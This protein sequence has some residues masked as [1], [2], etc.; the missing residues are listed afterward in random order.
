MST[1]HFITD[2]SRHIWETKYRYRDGNTPV[3]QSIE[4]TWK[5]IATGLAEAEPADKGLWQAR[6]YSVL[7]NF[8]F[9][10]AG[11]IHAG[12]NTGRRVTLFNCFVMGQIEDSM[13]GIFDALKE[14]YYGKF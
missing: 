1:K 3:D 13:D 10:P 9:L 8:R 2:I 12:I 7:E 11:R 6:F 14:G 5:R 4:D